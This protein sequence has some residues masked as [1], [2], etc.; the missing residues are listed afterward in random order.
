M[1]DLSVHLDMFFIQVHFCF[2]F[3]AFGH[4]FVCGPYTYLYNFFLLFLILN[5]QHTENRINFSF[6]FSQKLNEKHTNDFIFGKTQ[7]IY[8]YT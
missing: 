3:V 4:L 6:W 1:H 2:Y 5:L 8:M 7:T